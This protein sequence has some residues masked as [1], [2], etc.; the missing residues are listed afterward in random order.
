MKK[1]DLLKL[2]HLKIAEETP[3]YLHLHCED[4]FKATSWK[5][6]DKLEDFNFFACAYM[7]VRDEY[8]DYHI[9]T[10]AEAKELDE[11]KHE[12]IEKEMKRNE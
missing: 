1:E 8:L 10:E 4:G 6:G 3:K 7:P 11:K 12:E 9:I 2:D 5:E